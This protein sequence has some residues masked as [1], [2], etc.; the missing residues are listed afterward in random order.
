VSA[1]L[2][3]N[4]QGQ[5]SVTC[6]ATDAASNTGTSTPLTVKLD[7]VAPGISVQSITAG[8]QPDTPGQ[9]TTTRWW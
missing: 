5:T 8:G 7:S 1:P 6:S 4:T 9:Q 2:S 3:I